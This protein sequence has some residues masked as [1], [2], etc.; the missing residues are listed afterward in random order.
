MI[1]ILL[2]H[3]SSIDLYNCKFEKQ[4]L[5]FSEASTSFVFSRFSAPTKLSAHYTIADIVLDKGS[6]RASEL[7]W[8][9]QFSSCV[10]PADWAHLSPTQ[11]T[12]QKV[13]FSLIMIKDWAKNKT[14]KKFKNGAYV[15]TTEMTSCQPDLISMKFAESQGDNIR[16][17]KLCCCKYLGG[18]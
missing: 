18:K 11:Q 2:N 12:H 10:F 3:V 9:L 16:H 6:M 1:T 17:N 13:E 15:K 8:L 14:S 7:P 5:G 4:I